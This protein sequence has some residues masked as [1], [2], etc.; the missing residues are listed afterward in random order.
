VPSS[1][2]LSED[3]GV[4]VW[5]PDSKWLILETGIG[6]AFQLH[7]YH[8]G[9]DHAYLFTVPIINNTT[10]G[11]MQALPAPGVE[12]GTAPYAEP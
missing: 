6:R 10:G 1:A 11:L 2:Q 12:S 9:R 4:P 5:T 8:P 3:G 7:A